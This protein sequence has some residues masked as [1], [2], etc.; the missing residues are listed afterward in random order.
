MYSNVITCLIFFLKGK[1][2]S[3]EFL[4][5]L[6]V[7]LDAL[8]ELSNLSQGL[9]QEQV[10][11]GK[12]YQMLT[13]T[14]QALTNQKS[15]SGDYYELYCTAAEAENFKGKIIKFID[16]SSSVSMDCILVSQ[17]RCTHNL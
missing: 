7:L 14:I 15:G 5:S 11:L 13:R 1:L 17:Y 4:H 12:A 6:A 3:I 8:Y 10:T 16:Y 2:E 9:Q